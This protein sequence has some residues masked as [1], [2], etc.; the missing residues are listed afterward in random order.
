MDITLLHPFVN[1]Q[2]PGPANRAQRKA[3]SLSNPWFSWVSMLANNRKVNLH[4]TVALSCYLRYIHQW[5]TEGKD[6][7]ASLPHTVRISEC[8]TAHPE[9]LQS[10]CTSITPPDLSTHLVQDTLIPSGNTQSIPAG[11]CEEAITA[12]APRGGYEKVHRSDGCFPGTEV[13]STVTIHR[14]HGGT[15]AGTVA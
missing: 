15:V 12:A 7:V 3:Q 10:S 14:P 6:S 5:K 2:K 9:C 11:D 8:D 1:E 13:L 4:S